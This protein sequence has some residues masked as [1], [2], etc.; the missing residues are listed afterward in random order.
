MFVRQIGTEISR[1]RSLS[2][3]VS[4]EYLNKSVLCMWT[5]LLQ[6]EVTLTAS[7]DF[8]LLIQVKKNKQ[9]PE[10]VNKKKEKYTNPQPI[11]TKK[12]TK[13]KI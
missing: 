4:I 2:I 8:A 11:T 7:V 1:V 10:E 3:T 5:V 9:L 12:S 6:I 13:L